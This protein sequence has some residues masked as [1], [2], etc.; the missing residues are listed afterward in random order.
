MDKQNNI[1]GMFFIIIQ[2]LIEIDGR[3]GSSI[4]PPNLFY[5]K[6]NITAGFYCESGLK[7]KFIGCQI[8]N[9]TT[10]D[11]GTAIQCNFLGFAGQFPASRGYSTFQQEQ[12]CRFKCQ[13]GIPF[14]VQ[15]LMDVYSIRAIEGQVNSTNGSEQLIEI[16]G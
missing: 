1:N 5:L 9:G 15:P 16:V 6:Y 4:N 13:R 11:T 7:I 10:I 2:Y 12:F 3:A 14:H 8:D